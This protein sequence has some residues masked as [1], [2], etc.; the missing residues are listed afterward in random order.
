MSELDHANDIAETQVIDYLCEHPDFF[1]AHPALLGLMAVDHPVEGAVSL[2]ERQVDV[3][4][5]HNATLE[6]KMHQAIMLAREQERLNKL[7]QQM[8]LCLLE[9]HDFPGLIHAIEQP[10]FQLF[11]VH[12]FC[13]HLTRLPDDLTSEQ[14]RAIRLEESQQLLGRAIRGGG[15][16]ITPL[17]PEVVRVL[18]PNKPSI[19]STLVLPLGLGGRMGLAAIGSENPERFHPCKGRAFFAFLTQ[20]LERAIRLHT[21]L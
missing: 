19:G 17:Q 4:R 3:L 8:A 14:V 20:L 2:I 12:A 1:Q 15:P 11:A 6:Q 18:F 16:I 21:D 13:L 10:L 5:A 9:P 7:C